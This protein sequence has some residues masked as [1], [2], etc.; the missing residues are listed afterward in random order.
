MKEE[1]ASEIQFANEREP[2]YSAMSLIIA[3]LL[4]V[5][6][7]VFLQFFVK[8]LTESAY[9]KPPKFIGT[10]S[11]LKNKTGY[12]YDG[13]IYTDYANAREFFEKEKLLSYET[14]AILVDTAVNVPLFLLAVTLVFSLGKRND[15]YKLPTSAF[16]TAM[17]V[18]MIALLGRL[19]IYIYKINQKLAI[20]GISLVLI[21]IFTI[22]VVY[23]QNRFQERKEAAKA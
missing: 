2:K 7:I 18:N 19:S 10:S 4:G 16:F 8:D 22:S 15:S 21:F 11:Y 5:T 20:Y 14:K 1:T 12:E 23:V 6:L 13:K 17:V 9:G 3:F